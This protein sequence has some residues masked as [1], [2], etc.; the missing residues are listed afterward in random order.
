MGGTSGI[1]LAIFT[2]A[3]ARGLRAGLDAV[4]RYGGAARGDRTMLDA[5]IPA[6]DALEAG[7]SMREAAAAARAGAD[8]TKEMTAAR[9][10]RSSYVRSDALAGTP[11]PGAV[12]VALAFEALA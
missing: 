9:A 3:A 2:A 11:D 8:A 10:G 12:A 4:Q 1:L 7:K 6:L 5:F